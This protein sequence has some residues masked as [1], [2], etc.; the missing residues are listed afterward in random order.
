MAV[1]W[2]MSYAVAMNMD[3]TDTDITWKTR[4]SL[5]IL[6]LAYK[7]GC[8]KTLCRDSIC[9]CYA[10]LSVLLCRLLS[11][12]IKVSCIKCLFKI[13]LVIEYASIPRHRPNTSGRNIWPAASNFT[14]GIHCVVVFHLIV[15]ELGCWTVETEKQTHTIW[16]QIYMSPN[17]TNVIISGTTAIMRIRF[18]DL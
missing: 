4:G 1:N 14:S 15:L 2:R 17:N 18:V 13:L 3:N 12:E 5:Q 16:K 7:H 10:T 9:L 8:F 11:I 6:H